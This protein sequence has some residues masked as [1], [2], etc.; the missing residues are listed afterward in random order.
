[1]FSLLRCSVPHFPLGSCYSQHELS[2]AIW[3]IHKYAR[4]QCLYCYLVLVNVIAGVVDTFVT[5]HAHIAMIEISVRVLNKGFLL[6]TLDSLE[7][8]W[9]CLLRY[10]WSYHR[11]EEDCCRGCSDMTD[12]ARIPLRPAI[13]QRV[14]VFIDWQVMSCAADFARCDAHVVGSKSITQRPS[15]SCQITHFHIS[16]TDVELSY[17]DDIPDFAD[18]TNNCPH[19]DDVLKI[20]EV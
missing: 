10:C 7:E 9:P 14:R 19:I 13:Y 16:V 18:F 20:R 17:D 6:V 1:M 4:Q 8:M 3:Y 12:T 2:L 11:K 15:N 5:T